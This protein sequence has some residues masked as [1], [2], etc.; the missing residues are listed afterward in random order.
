VKQRRIGPIFKTRKIGKITNL[1]VLPE[2]RQGGIGSEILKISSRWLK[3]K[4]AKCT[5]LEASSNLE[6]LQKFYKNNGYK[7][8]EK[9]YFRGI[10]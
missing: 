4:G 3:G 10:S 1:F 5:I 6:R 7:E 2:Y 8:F 9:R